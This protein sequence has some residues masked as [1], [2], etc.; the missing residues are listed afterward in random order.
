MVTTKSDLVTTGIRIGN[1]GALASLPRLT[2]A[3]AKPLGDRAE[4]SPK[5]I[6]GLATA[7]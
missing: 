6:G 7:K 1:T 3:C 4:L 5:Q 2:E